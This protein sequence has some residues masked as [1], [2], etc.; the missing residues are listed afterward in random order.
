MSGFYRSIEYL[1]NGF[2]NAI[3]TKQS[4]I[5]A[6]NSYEYIKKKIREIEE[7]A[8]QDMENEK[9]EKFQ[10]DPNEVE[11]IVLKDK[12]NFKENLKI[13]PQ[14][15]LGNEEKIVPVKP[16]EKDERG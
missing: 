11:T 7:K 1:A 12:T 8:L 10:F 6:A 4:I 2:N 3:D 15:S 13:E 14:K 9:I 5:T 16:K